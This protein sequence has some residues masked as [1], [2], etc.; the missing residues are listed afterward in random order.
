MRLVTTLEAPADIR[1]IGAVTAAAFANAPHTS[2]T[3]R[4][5]A[6]C[7]LSPAPSGEVRYHSAFDGVA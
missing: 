2:R 7:F 4:F 5:T 3:E 1:S 6:S